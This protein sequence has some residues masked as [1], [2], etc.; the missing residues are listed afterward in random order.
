MAQP[1]SCD[2]CQTLRQELDEARRQLAIAGEQLNALRL[3]VRRP[4]GDDEV[5]Y[6]PTPPSVGQPPLRYVVADAANDTLKRGVLPVQK[7]FRQMVSW[8][9]KNSSR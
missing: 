7:W 3:V 1:S 5:R 8:A 4:E 6:Y 2:N 9:T